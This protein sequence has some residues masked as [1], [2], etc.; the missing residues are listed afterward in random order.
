M[1]K[2]M[3]V[4]GEALYAY[5]KG[6]KKSKLYLTYE[7]RDSHEL[8]L[9]A[10]FRSYKQFT[11]LEKK[12]I[13]LCTG[14]ILDVGCGTGYHIPYLMKRGRTEGIDISEKA[15]Q[16][17]KEMGLNNCYVADI[18]RFSTKK[19]YDTITLLQNN[20]GMA[21]TIPKTK[22]MLMILSNLLSKDGQILLMHRKTKEKYKIIIRHF[23]W[24]NKKSQKFRWIHHNAR[25]LSNLCKELGLRAD[26]IYKDRHYNLIRITRK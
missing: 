3:D 8:K 2:S 21:E 7:N 16:V 12:L 11:K 23:E 15:I 4:F 1:K 13:S 5:W 14:K 25:Y 24:K 19:K 17:A 10:Y 18:F 26:I 6:D 22:K 9:W 20:L